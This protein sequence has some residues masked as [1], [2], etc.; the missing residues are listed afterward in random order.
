MLKRGLY[1]TFN[2]VSGGLEAAMK[3]KF[4][5]GSE[6]NLCLAFLPSDA[7]DYLLAV[8]GW[9]SQQHATTRNQFAFK[10]SNGRGIG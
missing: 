8:L 1:C 10:I 7:M 9:F 2:G 6:G 3:F 4:R 5:L